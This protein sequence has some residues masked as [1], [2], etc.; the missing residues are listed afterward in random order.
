[1]SLIPVILCG[2]AGSRLWP[3]SRET[4]PKPFIR[5]GDGQSLLQKAFLRGANLPDVEQVLTVTNREFF[6]KTEDE[7]R[8]VNRDR[9]YT[10]FMLEPFGRN[11]AAAVAA[12]TLRVAE[13]HPDATLLILAAD[14]LIADQQAFADAVQAAVKL[15]SEGFLVT[16]GIKP[17]APETGYGYIEAEGHAVKRFVEK[18]DAQTAQAYLESGR[19][20]WNSGMFCFKA[21]TMLEEMQAHCSDILDAVKA[22][23][24]QSRTIEGKGITQ[25][26]LEAGSFSLVP[27]NSIDYAVMERSSRY[28][29]CSRN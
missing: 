25:T 8:V 26:E 29:L 6:F 5:L 28:I 14:H 18:P 3:V 16:F 2:G 27:E 22:C 1:M 23:L 9:L 10:E 21:R 24:T 12:A 15:A 17:D 19:F 20:F 13:K 4:H 7:F 11:T